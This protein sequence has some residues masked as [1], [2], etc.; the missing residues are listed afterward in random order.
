MRKNLW[1]VVAF[2]VASCASTPETI[3]VTQESTWRLGPDSTTHR[4][5]DLIKGETRAEVISE[6]GD[7][8]SSWHF[9]NRPTVEVM[10]YLRITLG[11]PHIRT[12]NNVTVTGPIFF[13]E[14]T[15]VYLEDGKVSAVTISKERTDD[16]YQE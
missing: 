7:P 11:P 3:P 14:T 2:L 9:V 13:R 4:A 15:F 1:L 5:I 8:K 6:L 16:T 10:R 12:L